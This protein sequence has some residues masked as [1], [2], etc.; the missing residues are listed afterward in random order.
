LLST[1]GIFMHRFKLDYGAL[2]IVESEAA[3]FHVVDVNKTPYWGSERQPGL[4][5]HLRLGLAA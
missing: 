4:I 5:E 2:D 1:A 3:E